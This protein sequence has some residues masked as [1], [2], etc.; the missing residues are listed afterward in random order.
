FLEALDELISIAKNGNCRAEVYH[1]KAAGRANWPKMDAAIEK[2]E[3]A[4]K[5]GLAI[6]A[7][8][9]TYLAGATGLD[10][11]MPPWVQEGGLQEW[12]KRLQDPAI[13]ARVIE[14]MRTPTDKWENL[15]LLS[16]GAHNVLLSG[17]K[18]EALKPLTGKRLSEVAKM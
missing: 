9:Y 2:I 15:L 8:M 13:R 17:F 1:L 6:T 4:R 10:A 12:R 7:D 18:S 5:S 16:G 11:A 14:E 3:A